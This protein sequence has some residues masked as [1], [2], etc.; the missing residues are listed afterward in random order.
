MG[1]DWGLEG[2]F[3]LSMDDEE[4]L[5]NVLMVVAPKVYKQNASNST[6]YSSM[7]MRWTFGAVVLFLTIALI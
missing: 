1:E 7:S 2:Y 4:C 3:H 5:S 6:K